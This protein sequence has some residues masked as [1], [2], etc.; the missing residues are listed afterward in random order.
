MTEFVPN[1][2]GE[3]AVTAFSTHWIKYVPP[4]VIFFLLLPVALTLFITAGLNAQSYGNGADML[5]LGALLL[6]LLVH[7]WY[8]HR[9]LSEAM[10]DVI[11]TNKR[12]IFCQD[13]LL[14]FDDMHEF[15]LQNLIAVQ[16]QKHGILQNVLRYG[17][18]WLDTGGSVST[19]LG[20][21]IPQVPHPH[22]VAQ[23]IT[24]E[25]RMHTESS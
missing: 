3:Y 19:D 9:I 25:R 20:G 5:F 17:S 23:Q 16:A 18:L 12:V 11:I 6:L 22:Y 7:H 1:T 4:T 2:N 24:T 15:N 10:V 8:F 14:R 21:V 13:S